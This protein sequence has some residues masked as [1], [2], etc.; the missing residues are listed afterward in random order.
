MEPVDSSSWQIKTCSQNA[1]YGETYMCCW[2]ARRGHVSRKSCF[3][4]CLEIIKSL[5]GVCFHL[6]QQWNS[7]H[8]CGVDVTTQRQTTNTCSLWLRLL[9]DGTGICFAS[10]TFNRNRKWR[11]TQNKR[12]LRRQEFWNRSWLSQKCTNGLVYILLQPL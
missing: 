6:L 1:H 12:L 10:L 3:K 8:T 11:Q 5:Q 9:I 2:K 7:Q 4:R